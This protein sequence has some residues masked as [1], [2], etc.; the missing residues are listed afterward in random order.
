MQSNAENKYK[1]PSHL[2]GDTD[3]SGN[4]R[5][6]LATGVACDSLIGMNSE[7]YAKNSQPGRKARTDIDILKQTPGLPGADGVD[8]CAAE[9]KSGALSGQLRLK[10]KN[11]HALFATYSSKIITPAAYKAVNRNPGVAT[12]ANQPKVSAMGQPTMRLGAG[13]SAFNHNLLPTSTRNTVTSFGAPGRDYQLG[14]SR[15]SND[16]QMSASLL[17]PSSSSYK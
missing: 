3:K 7:I 16:L 14:L 12:R 17:G 8:T 6:F 2:L 10:E 13:S 5:S 11:W 9:G 15:S 1:G 4:L